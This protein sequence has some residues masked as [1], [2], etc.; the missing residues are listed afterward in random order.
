MIGGWQWCHSWQSSRTPSEMPAATVSSSCAAWTH[1]V[2]ANQPKG[3]WMLPCYSDGS[4]Y[5]SSPENPGT[6]I[7]QLISNTR[8]CWAGGS[9]SAGQDLSFKRT[10]DLSTQGY[11][12][13]PGGSLPR[14][15]C[16]RLFH[17]SACLRASRKMGISSQ[18]GHSL[19]R[20]KPVL[21][22]KEY[23][24]CLSTQQLPG[25]N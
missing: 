16:S 11:H 21:H 15:P 4:S 23:P 12:T 3:G 13:A 24:R 10:R 25:E 1:D 7:N 17:L 8:I 6:D 5:S 2:S 14:A 9:E 20:Y 18:G 19:V 22:S